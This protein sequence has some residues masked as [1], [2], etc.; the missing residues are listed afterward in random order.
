MSNYS[1]AQLIL[2]LKDAESHYD[3]KEYEKAW[4]IFS[5][6]DTIKFKPDNYHLN[7]DDI[8]IFKYTAR[9]WITI[10][11]FEGY[12]IPPNKQIDEN[13]KDLYLLK[14]H[15]TGVLGVKKDDELAYKY[16]KEVVDFIPNKEIEYFN[17]NTADRHLCIDFD[18]MQP[19]LRMYEYSTVLLQN[20]NTCLDYCDLY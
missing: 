3:N 8:N 16:Y 10:Y 6:I 1:K 13:L 20:D 11:I 18:D 2:R 5:E 19:K 9:F 4:T 12:Y 7:K 14:K 15:K 17:S